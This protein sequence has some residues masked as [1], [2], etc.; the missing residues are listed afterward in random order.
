MFEQNTDVLWINFVDGVS[1]LL[2]QMTSGNA[3]TTYKILKNE[4]NT[5]RTRLSAIIRLWPIYAVEYFDVYV[6]LTDEDITVE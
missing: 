2:D 3:L 4:N 5:D 6:Q 1:Q